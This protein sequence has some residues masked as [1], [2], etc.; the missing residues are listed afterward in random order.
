MASITSTLTGLVNDIFGG[1]RTAPPDPYQQRITYLDRLEQTTKVLQKQDNELRRQATSTG[2]V[3]GLALTGL[4]ILMLLLDSTTLSQVL[5]GRLWL[6]TILG[7]VL[8]GVAYSTISRIS[9]WNPLRTLRNHLEGFRQ[10]ILRK[11][12]TATELTTLQTNSVRYSHR[13]HPPVVAGV[14]ASI[15]N[16]RGSS[17][18][19]YR[20]VFVVGAF[21]SFG[22]VALLYVAIAVVQRLHAK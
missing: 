12:K 18:G 6:L 2:I 8:M 22:L 14:C 4:G 13:H 3:L 7:L 19:L 20:F 17:P 21:F 5:G 1:P 16:R 15:A 9:H 10:F 11:P